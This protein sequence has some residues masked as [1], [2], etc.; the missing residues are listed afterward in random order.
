MFRPA[1]SRPAASL[2]LT[3][4]VCLAACMASSGAMARTS[5]RNQQMNVESDTNDCTLDDSGHCTLTGNVVITQG[6]LNIRSGKAVIYRNGGE[7]SR[8]VINGSPAVMRQQLDDGSPMTARASTIDYDLRTEIITLTGNVNIEQPRG[9]MTG[10]RVVYNTKTGQVNSGGGQNGGRVRMT[11]QPR[12]PATGQPQAP[13]QP[14][15]EQPATE[16]QPP[17]Q[18]D[19]D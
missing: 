2:L 6:T 5:D 18:Q 12:N 10:Q 14:P 1:A 13:A 17:N 3:G 4:A 7:P 8:A 15:A 19:Q 16:Q 11:I 9:T